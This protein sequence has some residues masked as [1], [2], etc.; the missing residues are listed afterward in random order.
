MSDKTEKTEKTEK[1]VLKSLTEFE[2]GYI[3][4][5]LWTFDENAPSGDYSISGRIEELFPLIDQDTLQ[6]IRNACNEFQEKHIDLLGQAGDDSQNGHDFWLSR[7][8]HGAGFFDRDYDNEVEG[9]YLSVGDTL[10]KHA[11]SCGQCDVYYGD[12]GNIYFSCYLYP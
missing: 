6:K 2:R 3:S 7:N 10:Q 8:H 11:Q 4:A 9:S 1:I 5:A 12:D